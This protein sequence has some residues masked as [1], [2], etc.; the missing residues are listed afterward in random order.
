MTTFLVVL[1]SVMVGTMLGLAAVL[2]GLS[3][4]EDHTYP[5]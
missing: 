3:Y 5:L 1:G 2:L 4:S